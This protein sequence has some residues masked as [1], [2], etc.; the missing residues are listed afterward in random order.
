MIRPHWKRI[1]SVYK[2][3]AHMNLRRAV[4]AEQELASVPKSV[5]VLC[6]IVGRLVRGRAQC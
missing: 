4:S 1:A 2:A 5:R 3:R 6:R